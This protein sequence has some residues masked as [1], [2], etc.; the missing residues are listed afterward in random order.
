MSI[1]ED[2]QK[3]AL[4]VCLKSWSSTYAELLEQSNLPSLQ[5]RRQHVKLCHLFKI[6]N[7]ATFFP[8]AP[9]QASHPSS[10]FRSVHSNSLV[11]LSSHSS[12]LYHSFFP[13]TIAAWNSLPCT[14]HSFCYIS[15]CIQVCSQEPLILILFKS[16]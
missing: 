5:T 9:I 12:Q 1:I 11:P 16:Y 14:Q 15:A 10:P 8:E 6:I 4:R 3:F 13:S 7:D 2:V